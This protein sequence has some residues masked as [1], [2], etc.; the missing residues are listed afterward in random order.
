[1]YHHNSRGAIRIT[2][3]PTG[4]SV[5]LE[6]ARRSDS[7]LRLKEFALR[8]LAA[9]VAAPQTPDRIVR[10]YDLTG[11]NAAEVQRWLDGDIPR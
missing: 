1:M 7:W 4:K 8:I 9:K 6:R 10:T 11:D 5:C 3:L 2:H